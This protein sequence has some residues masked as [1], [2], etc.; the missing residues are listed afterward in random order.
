MANMQEVFKMFSE[1]SKANPG[2][3]VTLHP[4]GRI[5]MCYRNQIEVVPV[6]VQEQEQED[7]VVVEE[8][9][10][11]TGYNRYPRVRNYRKHDPEFES[12]SDE[13]KR[14][15]ISEAVYPHDVSWEGVN[16]LMTIHNK[17]RKMSE[18]NMFI[19]SIPNFDKKKVQQ[20]Q[21]TLYQVELKESKKKMDKIKNVVNS[22]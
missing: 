5:T 9:A 7:V 4:D 22:L 8:Q 11:V 2:A 20:L 18:R 12:L 1:I 17:G 10:V 14:K 15:K 6:E 21:A 3:E 16:Y 13:E 19:K